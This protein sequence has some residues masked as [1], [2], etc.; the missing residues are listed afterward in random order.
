MTAPGDPV[1]VEWV[2]PTGAGDAYTLGAQ[3]LHLGFNWISTVAA[4]VWEPGVY[5][6]DKV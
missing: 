2:Q 5:G 4:N 3:V 1:L 6:W